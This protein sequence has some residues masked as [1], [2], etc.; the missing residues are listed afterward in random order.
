MPRQTEPNVNNALGSLLQATL[1][2]SQVR[3][4]NTQAISG[5]PGLRPDIIV[6]APGR[7]PVALEAEYMPARTVEPEARSRLGLEVA[8]NGRSIEAALA[9]R[10]PEAVSQADDL[11]AS[12]SEARLSYCLFTE[13]SGGVSRFP[14]SG[15]LE[16]A[17]DDLADM[18]QSWFG[19]ILPLTGPGFPPGPF[20]VSALF[21]YGQR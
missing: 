3:S 20:S 19:T 18:V 2:R 15:W 21:C 16:G 9:V 17:I 4:E 13:D 7:S 8:A 12:L 10:Y 6:A 11:H 1:P 14:E 5:H